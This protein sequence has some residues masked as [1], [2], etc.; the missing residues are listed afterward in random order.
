MDLWNDRLT[1][2]SVPNLDEGYFEDSRSGPKEQKAPVAEQ[3]SYEV[4]QRVVAVVS[5][6]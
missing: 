2:I 5:R 1:Q 6:P 4:T 3:S